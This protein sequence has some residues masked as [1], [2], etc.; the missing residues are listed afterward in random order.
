MKTGLAQGY[1]SSELSWL[2]ETN[3]AM[4]NV[5]ERLGAKL[6]KRYRTYK[7]MV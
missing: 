2:L 3:T 7:K 5:A 4:I 6:D 1:Q